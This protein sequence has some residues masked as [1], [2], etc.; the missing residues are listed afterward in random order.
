MSRMYLV[1]TPQGPSLVEA[2]TP[3]Q[4]IRI[5]TK[6]SIQSRPVSASEAIQLVEQGVTVLMADKADPETEVDAPEPDAPS[7]P[8]TE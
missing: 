1:E 2:D 4:S 8:E 7:E 3:A 6:D 5:V